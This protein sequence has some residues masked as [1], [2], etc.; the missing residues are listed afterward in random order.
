[1]SSPPSGTLNS[2]QP[3][4]AQA[5]FTLTSGDFQSPASAPTSAPGA[6]AAN[7]IRPVF[8]AQATEG[9]RETMFPR[10]ILVLTRTVADGG[11]PACCRESYLS[12]ACRVP[13]PRR[14]ESPAYPLFR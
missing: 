7:S 6:L 10:P 9:P 8:A 5:D 14:G 1:M 13:R 4:S 12:A 3:E 2:L 11:L